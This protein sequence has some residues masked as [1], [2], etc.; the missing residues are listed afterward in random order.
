MPP[1]CKLNNSDK[2]Q[3]LITVTRR[4][5]FRLPKTSPEIVIYEL[6]RVYYRLVRTPRLNDTQTVDIFH[7]TKD[8]DTVTD[9][10]ILNNQDNQDKQKTKTNP[11]KWTTPPQ[12]QLCQPW[13]KL[14]QVKPLQHP[15]HV[16][17]THVD[18]QVHSAHNDTMLFT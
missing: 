12:N 7:Y 5:R 2:G 17:C 1:K 3:T 4:N 11:P 10:S 16:S 9:T 6:S 15:I 14:P 18:V 8:M 13:I